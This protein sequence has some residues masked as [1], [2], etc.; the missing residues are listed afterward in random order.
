MDKSTGERLDMLHHFF[1]AA[2]KD[3]TLQDHKKILNEAERLELKTKAP[4]LLCDVLFD[5]DVLDQIKT[6][7]MLLYRF[8]KD[9]QKA[10]RHFLGGVEQLIEKHKDLL[11]PRAPHILKELYDHDLVDEDVI[12][13]WGSKVSFRF[14]LLN[15]V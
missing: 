14:L 15:S 6:H 11:L 9:D 4:L 13:A 2:K 10:Q 12:I 5:A 1:M 8:L 7:Q 3:G